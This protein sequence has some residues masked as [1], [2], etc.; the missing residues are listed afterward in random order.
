MV[1]WDLH[2]VEDASGVGL[3]ECLAG[4]PNFGKQNPKAVQWSDDVRT[5]N[6][7]NNWDLAA[8]IQHELTRG[9]SLNGGYYFNNGGYYRNTNSVQ[10]VSNNRAWGVNDF[11]QFCVTAPQDTRLPGEIGRAHV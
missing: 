5:K 2:A 10:R 8:E 9:I 6:R 3:R 4:D 7:D 11:D 1:K